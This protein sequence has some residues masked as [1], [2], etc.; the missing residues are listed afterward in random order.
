MTYKSFNLNGSWEMAYTPNAYVSEVLPEFEFVLIDNAVPGYWEDM[1]DKFT[2][3]PFYRE[4]KVNPAFGNQKYPISSTAPDMALP[5]YMGNF[6]YKRSF[7]WSGKAKNAFIHFAGVQNTARVWLNGVYLGCHKGYSTPFDVTIPDGALIDG[8]NTV[9]ISVSNLPMAGYG[10]NL[11]SGLTNRAANEYT[12][13][14]CGNVELRVKTSP[15]TDGYYVVS[16]DCKNI[17]IKL[18]MDYRDTVIWELLDGETVIKNGKSSGDFTISAEGL[19]LWTP[20]NPRLYTVRVYCGDGNL[21]ISLGVRRFKA[22]GQKFRLNGKPCF[23]RGVCEHCY[24]P[25]TIHPN[26]DENYYRS[27]VKR[28]KELGFNFIR[29]HTYI[30]EEEYMKAADELG[31]LLHVE[32][33]NNTTF[34]EWK[35]IVRFCRKHP[36]VVIY[37]CGNEL[38][39]DEPFIAHLKKCADEVHE[40]TDALFSPMSALRGVEYHWEESNMTKAAVKEPF[41]H[42]PD[43]LEVLSKFSDMYSSYANELLSYESLKADPV[44]IDMWGDKVY[45][46][47]RVSHEI[48]IDGT[49]TDLSLEA[50]CQNM[51][52]GQTKMFSSIREHLKDK[53]VLNNA[54]LYFKNSSMWQ[55]KIRKYCFEATRRCNNMA[56]F[57]FLGP[58]DTHWHTFGYDVGMMNEFYELKPGET[59]R[60]VLMYNSSTVLLNDLGLKVN[61]ESGEKIKG[62]ILVSYFGESDLEEADFILRL[63]VGDKPVYKEETKIYGIKNGGVSNVYKMD[64]E[65]PETDIPKE[66]KLSVTLDGK[67]V[68]AENEWELY[69]FPKVKKQNEGNLVVSNGM[70]AEELKNHLANGKDVVLFGAEPFEALETTFRIGLAGRCSGNVATVIYDHPI[71]KDLPHKG[72][73]SWQFSSL[74]EGG[75]SV[76][77]DDGAPFNPI[78]EVVSTHKYVIRQSSL[79]EIK[80]LSGR[81]IVCSMN[82]ANDD[83]AANW[84]KERIISYAKSSDFNPATSLTNTEFDALLYSKA[85]KAQANTNFAFNLNDKASQKVED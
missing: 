84:L 19:D 11:I 62:N 65:L 27:I 39:I 4:L 13:G 26:H 21:D 12:G 82:F 20:E 55:S 9:V 76:F 64:I 47:P 81:L 44:I 23:L 68:Y 16:D 28:L 56:G 60:N 15:L 67:G 2:C 75:N 77:F 36:S 33:P 46:K 30:P 40:G 50:R 14:I 53:G 41:Y 74:M 1:K 7:E 73:C 25:E 72:F 35:E 45:K 31:M 5:N 54:P 48:C 43:R 61:Y 24:F 79:F 66:L 34:E 6:F 80:A 18:K 38:L 3:A 37:C 85:K 59:V 49:Y 42:C 8:T 58:I 78:V 69:V 83:P 57:D 10:G 22:D 32:S 17:D 71:F 51:P 70:T 63:F 29:F 52:S